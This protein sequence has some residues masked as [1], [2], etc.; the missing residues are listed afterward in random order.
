MPIPSKQKSECCAEGVP[1]DAL[2]CSKQHIQPPI[3]S[4]PRDLHTYTDANKNGK[5]RCR[6]HPKDTKWF[7]T[8]TV[9]VTNTSFISV[10]CP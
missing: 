1:Q 9:I 6:N 5:D 7:Q 2:P 10:R 8:T 4:L 3:D